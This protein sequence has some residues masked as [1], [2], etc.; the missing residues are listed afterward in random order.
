MNETKDRQYYEKLFTDYPD[1]VDTKTVRAM[2]GGVGENT[3]WQLIRAGHLQHIH[4]LEQT[5]LVP[6]DWLIDYITGEHYAQYK[7]KLKSQV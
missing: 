4:Y 5:Y 2:L 7:N 3:V 6:K 1:V